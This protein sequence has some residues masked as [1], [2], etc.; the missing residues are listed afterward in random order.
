MPPVI[1]RLGQ[2]LLFTLLCHSGLALAAVHHDIR[3]SLQPAA[4]TLEVE[5]SI[6]LPAATSTVEFLLHENL[7]PTAQDAGTTLLALESIQEEAP[8]PIRR[9][10]A[11]LTPAGTQ[12]RL[13][14]SGTIRHALEQ[15]SRDYGGDMHQTSGLIAPEGVYLNSASFWYPVIGDGQVSFSLRARLPDGWKLVSQGRP[16]EQENGLDGWAED[17]PQ[18]DIYVIAAPY[19]EYQRRGIHADAMV[20]LR[21]N[22]PALAETYLEATEQYLDLY[23]RLL[24]DYPYAKFALV[25]NFWE[26]GY[27]MPSFTLLGPSVIRLPFIIHTSYPHEILHNWWGNGVYPDY[28]SGNWSEG[29]TSYLA[30]HLLKEQRGEG[31]DYRRSS[32]QGYADFV[33][34]QRDFPL[35]DFRSRHGQASQAVGYGKAMM[36]FHML[37]RQLGDAVFMDGLR[38]FY[39]DHLFR[40]AD[41]GNLQQAFEAASGQDLAETFKQW[42]NRPGAP[43]LAVADV[44]LVEGPGVYVLSAVLRQTQATAAFPLQVPV[45]VQLD[46]EA[47][48][49][50]HILAMTGKTATLRLELKRRPLRLMVDPQFDLFRQLDPSEIP[51]SIGQ[52]FGAEQVLI[53]LPSQAASD[54]KSS[55]EQLAKGWAA[56]SDQIRVHWDDQLEELPEGTA[57]WLLG[58]DNR[59]LPR[60]LEA[61]AGMP[62][63]YQANG[64]QIG[65]TI[66]NR[67]EHSVAVTCR[68]LSPSTSTLGWLAAADAAAIPGLG[69]K[70]PHYMKYSYL[71]FEGD[72]PTNIRK[73]HWPLSESALSIRLPGAES[74]PDI[75]L[76]VQAPLSALVDND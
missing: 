4:G 38:R 76:P 44:Q 34:E 49:L 50:R 36:F 16:L 31:T 41:F 24:G 9:Y 61:A 39:R 11:T 8:V 52:L 37:R 70:L 75:A 18:D 43:A 6:I 69:R 48:P 26:T 67:R 68:S 55:Y 27:G 53:V 1:T 30:D 19:H 57:V 35:R 56:R 10:R 40:S 64:L 20:F 32:L 42:I 47:Q 25:E 74:P 71:V 51:S 17:A 65:D 58:W 22:D 73:A 63:H 45:L 59:L 5:D 33:R 14:Y 66:Y 12:L 2:C 60:L 15:I 13:R 46:G 28:A 62:L 7:R 54:E 3:I 72:A 21:T 23:S 29:L